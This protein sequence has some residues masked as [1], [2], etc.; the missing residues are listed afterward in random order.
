MQLPQILC[1]N[2]ISGFGFD[3]DNTTI[4]RQ[5]K[6]RSAASPFRTLQWVSGSTFLVPSF[7]WFVFI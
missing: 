3:M 6:K 5:Q 4:H 2:D 7:F 1:Y